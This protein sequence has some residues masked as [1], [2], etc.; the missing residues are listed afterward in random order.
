MQSIDVEL[1]LQGKMIEPGLFF[2]LL[3]LDK[4]AQGGKEMIG[5]RGRGLGW[6]LGQGTLVQD[7][8]FV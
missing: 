8:F 1:G 6:R 5:L 7:N 4:A 2:Q 3:Q